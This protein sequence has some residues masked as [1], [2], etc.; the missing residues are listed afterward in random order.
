MLRCAPRDNV[1]VRNRGISARSGLPEV[2]AIESLQTAMGGNIR[3]PSQAE[4]PDG[5]PITASATSLRNLNQ[6]SIFRV[7]TCEDLPF[8]SKEVCHF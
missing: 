4:T 8:A 2:C 7:S 5:R 6:S 3:P 1:E